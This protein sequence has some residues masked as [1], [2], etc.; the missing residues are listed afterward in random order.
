LINRGV[1]T[2]DNRGLTSYI[3]W[4]AIGKEVLDTDT[5]EPFD[6]A[7]LAQTI[8]LDKLL[9]KLLE[10]FQVIRMVENDDI[11]YIEEEDNPVIH[12]EA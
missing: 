5:Q 6:T 1:S 12:P 11:I 2:E 8:D 7:H 9:L 3:D 10:V 4:L